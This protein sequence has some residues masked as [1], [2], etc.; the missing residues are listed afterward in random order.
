MFVLI[1]TKILSFSLSL[2]RALSPHPVIHSLFILILSLFF[3][4]SQPPTPHYTS[5]LD[6]W[7][8]TISPAP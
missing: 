5:L 7:I 2:T 1:N 6:I 4:S 3:S 8:D